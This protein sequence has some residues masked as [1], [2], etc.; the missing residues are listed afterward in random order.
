MTKE[1][2]GIAAALRLPMMVVVTK[3]DICPEKVFHK[4]LTAINKTLK[5]MRRLP[6]PLRKEE[7][8]P[9]AAKG[10]ESGKVAPIICVSNVTGEGLDIVR[11]L[12]R[13]LEPRVMVS[14][15]S[16]KATEAHDSKDPIARPLT[17][18]DLR[19]G[20]GEVLIDSVFNVPG[21]GTVA[22]G[23]VLRG[24]I[25]VGNTM[26]VGPDSTGSFTPVTVRSIQCQYTAVEEAVAGGSAAFA[27]RPK[28]KSVASSA[29]RTWLRKG[30]ALVDPALEPAPAWGFE[31]EVLVLH[32]QTTLAVGYAPIMHIGVAV[33]AARLLDIR[34]REGK[35]IESLRTGDRAVVRCQFMYHPEYVPRDATLLFREG[36]A[37]GV[38]RVLNVF[39]EREADKFVKKFSSK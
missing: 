17:W 16:K 30:M 32:H 15:P 35:P 39:H 13:S 14:K 1:H 19:S 28:L 7:E 5:A 22:A 4:T 18:E 31:A 37:K 10:M 38:G 33:Q 8:I 2:L 26:M 29:R 24:R 23:T 11:H 25:C 6:M 21:V 3:I 20:P 34:S 36:R 27:I 9:A 12:L